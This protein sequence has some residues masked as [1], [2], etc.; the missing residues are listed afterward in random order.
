VAEMPMVN[1]GPP[2]LYATS[3]VLA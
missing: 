1:G 3:V 2:F